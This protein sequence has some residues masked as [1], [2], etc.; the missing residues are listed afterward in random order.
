MMDEEKSTVMAAARATLQRLNGGDA[1]SNAV[2]AQDR[3]P[4][5]TEVRRRFEELKQGVANPDPPQQERGCNLTDYEMARWRQYFE[6]YVGQEIARAQEAMVEICGQGIGEFW[7]QRCE[8]IQQF[9]DAKFRHVPHGPA[10]ERGE[11]G[12]IGPQG[13]PG[14]PGARGDK[15]DL[16]ERGEKGDPGTLPLVQAYVPDTVHYAGDVVTQS[17]AL[18]QA[19]KDTGQAPPHADWICLA[20]AGADGITPT[21]RSTYDAAVKYARLDIVAL[22]GTTFIARRD[23][24]GKCPGDGWQL[25]S[26][27]GKPGIKGPPGERGERGQKGDKGDPSPTIV[28]WQIDQPNYRAIPVMSDGTEGPPLPLRGLFEQFHQETRG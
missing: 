23:N 27:R 9:V 5:Q 6:D 21:V 8:E 2:E 19:T 13:E 15:G 11:T 20:A 25:M 22:D 16:G 24:P 26:A 3:Q 4:L 7:N 17:A 12:P 18:W 14:I 28:G 1:A 10:G